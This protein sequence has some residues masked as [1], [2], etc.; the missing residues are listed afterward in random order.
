MSR[1]FCILPRG[2]SEACANDCERRHRHENLA[3]IEKLE[4]D[5]KIE[6]LDLHPVTKT[7]RYIIC[8]PLHDTQRT[9]IPKSVIEAAAGAYKHHR[10]ESRL[11]RRKVAAYGKENRE[12]VRLISSDRVV[13]LPQVRWN[14]DGITTYVGGSAKMEGQPVKVVFHLR[15]PEAMDAAT[16]YWGLMTKRFSAMQMR[17]LFEA[18]MRRRRVA[19][20]QLDAAWPAIVVKF[21]AGPC[22]EELNSTCAS[23]L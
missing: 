1:H 13:T 15:S 7:A 20:G 11:G 4:A 5:G 19:L 6:F 23:E 18:E 3:G 12:F 16:A 21:K 14:D 22:S 10:G 17:A 2:F 9:H 8:K